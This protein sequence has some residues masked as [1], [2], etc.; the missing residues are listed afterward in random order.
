MPL[1]QLLVEIIDII[2]DECRS[3]ITTLK[4]LSCVSKVLIKR[5]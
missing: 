5:S 4:V 2:V 3:D 1:T